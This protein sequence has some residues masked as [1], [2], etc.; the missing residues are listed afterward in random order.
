MDISTFLISKP[1]PKK[2][3]QG[4][5][6]IEIMVALV[7]SSILMAGVYTIFN[8]SKKTYI[9][10]GEMAELNDNAR[11]IMDELKHVISKAGYAGCQGTYTNPFLNSQDNQTIQGISSST[12]FPASDILDINNFFQPLDVN[13]PNLPLVNPIVLDTNSM[14]PVSTDTIWI[15]N[16][17]FA[18]QSYSILTITPATTPWTNPIID[19]GSLINTYNP[20]YDIY[21]Q[22]QLTYR[23]EAQSGVF[24]LVK[25]IS[26]NCNTLIEGVQNIQ[27]RYG[28]DTDG[29]RIPDQ[30]VDAGTMIASG[31]NVISIRVTLLMRTINKRG[32]GTPGNPKTFNLDSNL[33]YNPHE[34]NTEREEG[35]RHRL[36]T[37]TIFVRNS[38]YPL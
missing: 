10:Q 26:G 23:V 33:S 19:I 5:S 17:S 9:L 18:P 15:G 25:C 2:Y 11:F 16:C 13:V 24:G 37:T 4:L 29:N 34:A 1:Y 21:M 35:Y 28:I 14:V 3:S 12:V 30:Y 32:I 7:I 8:N 22:N 20:P 31:N 38:I 27:I 6:I 36:F